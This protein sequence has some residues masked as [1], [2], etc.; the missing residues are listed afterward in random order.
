ML[1]AGEV[2]REGQLLQSADSISGEYF[3]AAQSEH[4]TDPALGLYLPAT[5]GV[6]TPSV[7]VQPA[8][9]THELGLAI[10][11]VETAFTHSREHVPPYFPPYPTLHS[12]VVCVI[13]PAA[14]LEFDGQ[15]EQSAGPMLSL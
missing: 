5:Q 9:Q 1:P 7:P 13:L 4:A 6:Q 2:E 10:P 11:F 3:P 12:H 8:L 14:E 15:S